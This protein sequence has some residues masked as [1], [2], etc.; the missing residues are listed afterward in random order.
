MICP[1]SEAELLEIWSVATEIFDI[2]EYASEYD[3]KNNKNRIYIADIKEA[4]ILAYN[5]LGYREVTIVCKR[6]LRLLSHK[7]AVPEL[8]I[9]I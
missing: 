4:I 9:A 6:C 1:F 2:S 5:R 8:N 7:F 3:S